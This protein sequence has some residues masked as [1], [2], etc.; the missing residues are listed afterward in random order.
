MKG[1]FTILP[2]RGWGIDTTER[3]RVN[4]ERRYVVL[5]WRPRWVVTYRTDDRRRAHQRGAA[6]GM[7]VLDT[8]TGE[9]T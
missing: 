5:E 6:M 9:V 8:E 3:V 4:S 1:T 2:Q 7:R